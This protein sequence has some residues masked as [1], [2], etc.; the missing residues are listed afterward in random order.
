MKHIIQPNPKNESA[1]KPAVKKDSRDQYITRE[2]VLKLLSDE[3]V[4]AVATA[5]TAARLPEGDEYLD[6]ERLDLGVQRAHSKKT[7]MGR[8]LP[9]KSIHG[10]TWDK[11]LKQLPSR[12][13][14]KANVA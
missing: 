9:K 4:S 11:I 5:E 14:A 13:A 7:P 12:P 2:S 3:E 10:N 6:L 8:A 1:D